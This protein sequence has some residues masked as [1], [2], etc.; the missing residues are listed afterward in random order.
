MKHCLPTDTQTLLLKACLTSSPKAGIY[1]SKWKNEVAV[2][3]DNATNTS[4]GLP[5]V[6]DNLD[7]GSQRLLSLLYYNLKSQGVEDSTIDKL[8]GYFKYV[9]LKNQIITKS[10]IEIGESFNQENVD[11]IA[12]KGISLVTNYYPH[13]GTRPTIDLDIAITSL[14]LK[15]VDRLLSEIGWRPKMKIESIRSLESLLSHA[16][17]LIK[18]NLELDLHQRFSEYLLMDKTTSLFWQKSIKSEFQVKFLCP[19][20]ELF[21]VIL[22]GM[23][24]CSINNIRWVA[25]AVHIISAFSQEDWNEFLNLIK[26]EKYNTLLRLAL[27]YLK[28]NELIDIPNPLWEEIDRQLTLNQSKSPFV[29]LMLKKKKVNDF[30][31]FKSHYLIAKHESDSYRSCWSL[32]VNHYKAFWQV[33]TIF[34]L[35]FHGSIQLFRKILYPNRITKT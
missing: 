34:Q 6:Y 15:D 11:V 5:Q 8:K 27:E 16:I 29:K 32:I 26:L 2:D 7:F 9:W 14:H 28:T 33:E 21:I 3:F 25:D 30:V 31:T 12:L 23:N 10:L 4:L 1:F 22:H 19:A 24:G 18:G 35:F 20:H 13:P 17:P